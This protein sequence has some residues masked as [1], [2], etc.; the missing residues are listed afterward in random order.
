MADRIS[1]QDVVREALALLDG[2][3]IDA[4][5]LR[6]VARRL[7]V[8]LNSVSLQ[9][10]NKARLLDLMA[11]AILGELSFDDLPADPIERIKAIFRNYRRVLLDHRDGAHLVS[12]TRVSETNTLRLGNA[13][14]AALLDAGVDAELAVTT[15]WGLNYFVVG[16]VHEE[17]TIPDDG[18]QRFEQE[19]EAHSFPALEAVRDLFLGDNAETRLEFGM[20]ALLH[21][22]RHQ[23]D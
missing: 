12:G 13:V 4:V 22:A 9:V 18:A 2:D 16:L 19:L 3:G 21:R 6:G 23:G 17:Q 20:D 8:H 1:R 15:F 5:T 10:G 14:I 7:G 11:D